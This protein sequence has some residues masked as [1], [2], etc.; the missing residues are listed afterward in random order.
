MFRSRFIA[1]ALL[2]LICVSSAHAQGQLHLR[3]NDCNGAVEI[4]NPC[5]SNL[6]LL[7]LAASVRPATALPGVTAMVA[8]VALY[9]CS[10]HPAFSQWWHMESGGCREGS[11]SGTFDFTAT[12]ANG[13]PVYTA[14]SDPW[15]AAATGTADDSIV[16]PNEASI[17][18]SATIP[19]A[20]AATFDSRVDSYLFVLKID[21]VGS[22]PPYNCAGCI[23]V[24]IFSLRQV[25][26]T[27][28]RGDTVIDASDISGAESVGY[29]TGGQVSLPPS[30]CRAITAAG[31][32]SWGLIKSIYR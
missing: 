8:R 5:I 4:A 3:V 6:G 20:N 31:S 27:S 17:L 16:A 25:T 18:V 30:P 9:G 7:Q 13:Y 21:K 12:D 11:L 32:S 15:M 19:A 2:A 28:P 23:D 26:L 22:A 29:N 1:C 24:S 14:C 10:L